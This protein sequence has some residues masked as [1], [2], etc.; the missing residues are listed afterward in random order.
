MNR[1]VRARFGLAGSRQQ[2]RDPSVGT[3]LDGRA[4]PRGLPHEPR[5]EARNLRGKGRA[6]HRHLPIRAPVPRAVNRQLQSRVGRD[7]PAGAA[8]LGQRGAGDGPCVVPRHVRTG[9]LHRPVFGCRTRVQFLIEARRQLGS[10]LR[11]DRNGAERDLPLLAH[12]GARGNRATR[13]VGA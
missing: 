2:R 9:P 5:Q 10:R 1:P 12:R 4:S 3:L 6:R 13:P 11:G 8:R 7:R